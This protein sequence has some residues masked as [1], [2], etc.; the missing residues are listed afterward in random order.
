MKLEGVLKHND[1]QIDDFVNRFWNEDER[2]Y[3]VTWFSST[4]YIQMLLW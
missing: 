3:V 1:R 2:C 4:E